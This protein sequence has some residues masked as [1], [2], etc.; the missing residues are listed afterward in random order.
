MDYGLPSQDLKINGETFTQA[1]ITTNRLSYH[2]SGTANVSDGF[3][4][5]VSDAVGNQ[6][7]L[8]IFDITITGL[9]PPTITLNGSYSPIYNE[10]DAP[11][12][13]DT[14]PTVTD[15]DSVTYSLLTITLSGT[16]VS[17]DDEVFFATTGPITASSNT[18]LYSGNPIGTYSGGTGTPIA[19]GLPAA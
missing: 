15:P 7:D 12:A 17:T 1:D 14:V 10:N 13:V 4:F 3:A 2:N 8:T 6:G 16:G 9:I 19:V 5:R 18:I 11:V